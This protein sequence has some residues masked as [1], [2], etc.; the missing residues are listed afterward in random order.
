MTCH[1]SR[2]EDSTDEK[3]CL[4][5]KNLLTTSQRSLSYV[6]TSPVKLCQDEAVFWRRP[7]H[8]Y[9]YTIVRAV[10][11]NSRNRITCVRWVWRKNVKQNQPINAHAFRYEKQDTQKMQDYSY[12]D[13][14]QPIWPPLS[15][16]PH[17]KSV[18]S[19]A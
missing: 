18:S 4:T 1:T 14:T 15:C 8:L 12:A 16:P 17:R 7:P 5:R 2:N 6:N 19:H 10:V 9:E 11:R 13:H 3:V